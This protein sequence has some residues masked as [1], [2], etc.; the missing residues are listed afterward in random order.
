MF[1]LPTFHHCGTHS[2]ITGK[3]H[4]KFSKG[5]YY[6]ESRIWVCCKIK[7]FFTIRLRDTF[8]LPLIKDD[9]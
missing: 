1:L 5:I 8:S 3:L 7:R 4:W 9:I 2:D 6:S